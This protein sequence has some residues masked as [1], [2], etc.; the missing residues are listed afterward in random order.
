[1]RGV[2]PAVAGV[3]LACA[4]LQ[5]AQAEDY[6][7][8]PVRWIVPFAAG[9]QTDSISRVI[10]QK[11]SEAWGVQVIADN[12]PGSAGVVGLGAA[13]KAVP[14]GYTL[15]V[16]QASN[17]AIAPALYAKLPYDPT[18]ELQAVTQVISLPGVLV[19]HPS[20]PARNIRDLIA[21]ARAKPGIVSYGSDGNGTISHLTLELLK[22]MAAIEI[23]HVP[24]GRT[25]VLT[26]LLGG[27]IALLASTLPPAL[28]LIKSNRLRALG[29]TSAK[30]LQPLPDVATI[31]ESGVPGYEAVNWYGVLL[32]AGTSSD[33]VAKVHATLMRVLGQPDVRE[34]FAADGGDIV[35]NTPA[36]FE[37]Y[38][39]KEIPKWAK[40]VR[41][42]G[43][44]AE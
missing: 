14:D 4:A 24:E 37:A 39:R 35:A 5:A 42:A 19:A 20:F 17:V 27:E 13:A 2:E 25:P 29:V 36:E 28:P 41:A 9:G 26:S 16:G 30:R 15:V 31:A 11:L 43:V 7:A 21:L 23:V 10:T 6:P 38:I 3:L 22:S 40:A 1:M 33:L 44:R 8:R 32:P 34:R 18:T 12:R